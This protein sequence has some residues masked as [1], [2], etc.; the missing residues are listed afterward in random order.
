MSLASDLINAV[1]DKGNSSIFH[2]LTH[3]KDINVNE[4]DEHGTTALIEA[5]KAHET[6]KFIKLVNRKDIDIRVKDRHGKT[7]MDYAIEYGNEMMQTVL[8]RKTPLR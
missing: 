8:K 7:A 2:H 4:C 1:R 3:L 6:L 5:V